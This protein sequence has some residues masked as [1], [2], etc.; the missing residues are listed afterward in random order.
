MRVT[1]FVRVRGMLCD[2]YKCMFV[3]VGRICIALDDNE[4]DSVGGQN[5]EDPGKS[6]Q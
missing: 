2:Y 1:L 3:F 5:V 4:F 6:V